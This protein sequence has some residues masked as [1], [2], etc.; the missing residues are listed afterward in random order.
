MMVSAT[1]TRALDEIS[2][3]Q[4]D[5]RSAFIPGAAS[6][7]G[8]VAR[9][10]KSTFTLDPLSAAAPADAYFIGTDER[11]RQTYSRDGT[12]HLQD[13]ILSDRFNQPVLGYDRNTGALAPL[14]VDPVD[15]A[16]GR[17]AD[18]QIAADGC[19]SYG[20]VAIDPAS[21]REEQTRVLVGR[22]AL[23]RFSAAT[24]LQTLDATRS[25][26]PPNVVPHTGVAG[27]SNFGAL[28][29]HQ[30][31]ESRIDFELAVER[32][33]EAY[34]AFDAMRAAHS[35]QGKV[36]KTAMDLLK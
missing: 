27:D 35:A 36:E 33:Q 18:L 16:L 4:Q 17:T 23:A 2:R 13:N 10:R 21:G 15:V 7:R 34:L 11:G 30:Q 25:L 12:F 32:L 28:A 3:R 24:K 26:A 5:L 31:E 19:V 8:D 1:A 6:E 20:R 22:L 9:P 14:R 29:T